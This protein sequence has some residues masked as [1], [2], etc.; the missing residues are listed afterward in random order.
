MDVSTNMYCVF[1][2]NHDLSSSSV[3]QRSFYNQNYNIVP[4]RI[5]VSSCLRKSS[6]KSLFFKDLRPHDPI[7]LEL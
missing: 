6:Q 7:G 2:S 3:P 5:T 4:N 1:A